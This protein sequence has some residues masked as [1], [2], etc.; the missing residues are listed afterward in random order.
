MKFGMMFASTGP[1]ATAEGAAT[2]ATEV[3]RCGLESIWAVEHVVIP[4]GYQSKYPYSDSGKIPGAD[5]IAKKAMDRNPHG[6]L[7]TPEDVAQ[8]LLA[9]AR[10]ETA[11]LTGNV[12]RVDGGEAI[13]A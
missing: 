6:R 3:E 4:D 1:F 9:L 5:D 2:M 11:W 8:C 13:S 12:L 7:T 10:P